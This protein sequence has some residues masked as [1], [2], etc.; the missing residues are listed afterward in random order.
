MLFEN[1]SYPRSK[2]LNGDRVANF[3]EWAAS[4]YICYLHK[5]LI[6]L[7]QKSIFV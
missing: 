7:L 3:I 4:V 6:K 2:V 5:T 1:L